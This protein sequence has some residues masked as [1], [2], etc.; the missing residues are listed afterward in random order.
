[1]SRSAVATL[2]RLT[3]EVGRFLG[4]VEELAV[5]SWN[6]RGDAEG[7]ASPNQAARA[8][9]GGRRRLTVIVAVAAAAII[10]SGRSVSP[11]KLR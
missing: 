10:L 11:A 5:D 2:S 1:L 9:R 7:L 6:E 8:R 4:L 3:S